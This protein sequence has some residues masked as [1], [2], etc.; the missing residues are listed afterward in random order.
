MWIICNCNAPGWLCKCYCTY[1]MYCDEYKQFSCRGWLWLDASSYYESL[2]WWSNTDWRFVATGAKLSTGSSFARDY[3]I[4]VTVSSS[5]RKLHNHIPFFFYSWFEVGWKMCL[6]L[7]C[8]IVIVLGFS[9]IHNR[10][11][12]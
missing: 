2:L 5:A 1:V 8:V 11:L 10:E 12:K 7:Y 3:L 9:A 6:M 4:R